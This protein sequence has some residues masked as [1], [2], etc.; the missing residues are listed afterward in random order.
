MGGG[1]R[2]DAASAPDPVVEGVGGTS[3]PLFGRP[4]PALAAAV[5]SAAD[6]ISGSWPVGTLPLGASSD[7][8]AQ[9]I[10]AVVGARR[11]A[12]WA[13]WAQLS[14]IARLVVAWQVLPPVS[15]E[16]GVEDRCEQ[17]GAADP[18]LAERLNVEIGRLQ[19]AAGGRFAQVGWSGGGWSGMAVE[20][21]PM[22]ASAGGARGGGW[23]RTG[24]ERRRGGRA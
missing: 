4:G 3:T 18:V 16:F 6:P 2:A 1:G 8:W 19:R 11:L 13:L 14:M 22:L 21:A 10:H 5:E 9:V 15:N 20:M 23:A 17:G 7:P 12:G 24:S